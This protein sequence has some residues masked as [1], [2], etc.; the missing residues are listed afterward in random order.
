MSNTVY[1][2]RFHARSDLEQIVTKQEIDNYRTIINNKVKVAHLKPNISTLLPG[3]LVYYATDENEKAHFIHRVSIGMLKE[4]EKLIAA[5]NLPY[6]NAR[7][8]GCNSLR[9]ARISD[10]VT[11]Y[12]DSNLQ[13]PYPNECTHD[14]QD[15]TFKMVKRKLIECDLAAYLISE[16]LYRRSLTKNVSKAKYKYSTQQKLNEIDKQLDRLIFLIEAI[17]NGVIR[18]FVFN[19]EIIGI[20]GESVSY[21]TKPNMDSTE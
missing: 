16:M 21:D 8:R 17:D 7:V 15:P 9:L 11:S 6:I 3:T 10:Q 14:E 13:R 19:R 1:V 12:I 18:K 20:V 4:L 5:E 2:T